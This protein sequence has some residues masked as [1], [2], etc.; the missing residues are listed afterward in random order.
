MAR[1]DRAH[2]YLIRRNIDR[3]YV[4]STDDL[5]LSIPSGHHMVDTIGEDALGPGIAAVLRKSTGA[6]Q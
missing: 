6:D 4:G 1:I 3:K 2:R 5:G